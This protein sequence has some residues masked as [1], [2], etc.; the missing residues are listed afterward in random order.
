MFVEWANNC[1]FFL[2]SFNFL[3]STWMTSLLATVFFSAWGAIC[4]S[5]LVTRGTRCHSFSLLSLPFSVLLCDRFCCLYMVTSLSIGAISVSSDPGPTS[6][7]P[8]R[9]EKCL[10]DW[11][12][13]G[14][15]SVCSWCPSMGCHSQQGTRGLGGTSQ[16]RTQIRA[17]ARYRAVPL[18][19]RFVCIQSPESFFNWNSWCCYIQTSQLSPRTH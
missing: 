2:P 6:S 9:F 14:S 10:L 13:S 8:E 1:A 18:C 17:L 11:I 19:K 4:V 16:S 7:T 5:P 12:K 15:R 3:P